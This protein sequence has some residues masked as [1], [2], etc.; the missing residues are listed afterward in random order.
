M[1]ISLNWLS[2]YIDVAPIRADLKG[3]LSR[4]TMRGLE[5]ESI[6]DLSK[7]FEKVI[8]AQIEARDPHPNAD[9]LSVCR[10]NTGK[11]V[12]QIVCGAKN[13]KAGDKVA[14][15]QIG[16]LLPNGMKIEKGKI[17]DVESFGMLC[18]ETE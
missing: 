15:S 11:E 6:E 4:L 9:R 12:L 1:K 7:G 2:E 8:I 18:S 5:V 16:A 13:M 17:R 14:L 3:V 10:V